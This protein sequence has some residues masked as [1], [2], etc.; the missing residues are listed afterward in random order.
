MSGLPPFAGLWTQVLPP[1]PAAESNRISLNALQQLIK[2]PARLFL[3]RL[4]VRL[5]ETP[6]E[7]ESGDL[8]KLNSLKKWSLRDRLL[9]ARVEGGSEQ[10]LIAHFCVAGEI[11]RETI[12]QAVATDLLKEIPKLAGEPFLA[13]DKINRTLQLTL[14]SPG[15][16]LAAWTLEGRLRNGWYRRKG[17]NTAYFFSASKRNLKNELLLCLEALALSASYETCPEE[18]PD[19][20]QFI[21]QTAKKPPS[22]NLPGPKGARIL[23][24]SLL[25]LYE[26]ARRLPLSFWPTTAEAIMK[27]YEDS[28]APETERIRAALENGL[29]KWMTASPSSTADAELESTRYAFRGCVNPLL[30]TPALP[31][32]SGL[33]ES[34]HPLAWRLAEFFNDWKKQ[35]G[36]S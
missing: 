17:A 3:E 30:W 28:K 8:L 16:N 6:G 35:A 12:G 11:P 31:S 2:E 20:V 10:E 13:S 15:A 14:R 22:L 7:L 25:P 9:S 27:S 36:L 21:F 26:A 23:L 24:E 4:G 19:Q 29:I 18:A 34:R 32:G 5:P 1:E 33:P